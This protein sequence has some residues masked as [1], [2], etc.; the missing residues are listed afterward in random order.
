MGAAVE[1]E[2]GGGA[3]VVRLGSGSS[4]EHP[5]MTPTSAHI[6][7]PVA[8]RVRTV[9][10]MRITL[11]TSRLNSPT[12]ESHLWITG[13]QRSP[14]GRRTTTVGGTVYGPRHD[15]LRR[16]PGRPERHRRLGARRRRR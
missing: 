11:P 8:R 16:R 15:P 12:P 7:A 13:R 10:P 4:S 6:A 1:A 9:T 14:C 3:V 5:T 2:V